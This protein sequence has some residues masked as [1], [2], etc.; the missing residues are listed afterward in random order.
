MNKQYYLS[1]YCGIEENKD[2]FYSNNVAVIESKKPKGIKMGIVGWGTDFGESFYLWM[3]KSDNIKIVKRPG[4]IN[5]FVKCY[6]KTKN[7]KFVKLEKLE[8]EM[9]IKD[10]KFLFHNTYK[11]IFPHFEWKE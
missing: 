8:N 3:Y 2:Y 4:F 6:L 1:L 9:N 11:E 10:D 5:P 7:D